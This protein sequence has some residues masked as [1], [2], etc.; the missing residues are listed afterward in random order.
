M[1]KGF[2]KLGVLVVAVLIGLGAFAFMNSTT[3]AQATNQERVCYGECPSVEFEASRVVEVDDTNNT[4][5]DGY[6]YIQEPHPTKNWGPDYCSKEETFSTTVQYGEKSQDPNHCHRPTAQSLNVPQ[7]AINDF[8]KLP[9]KKDKPVIQCEAPKPEKEV[10]VNV[11]ELSCGVQEVTLSGSF[12]YTVEVH[13]DYLAVYVDGVQVGSDILVD[14]NN[15]GWPNWSIAT[16]ELGVGTHTVKVELYDQAGHNGLITTH[17]TEFEIE[18][19]SE[20]PTPTPTP[21]D[22]PKE[23]TVSHAS[24][25]A[26]VCP[27]GVTINLPANPHVERNGSTAVVKW[28]QTEGDSANIYYKEVNSSNW[29][30]SVND[31]KVDN[32]DKFGQVTINDLD[33]NLGYTFGIQQK[34]GCGGGQTVTAIIIDGP[35][36]SLFYLSYWEWA[37]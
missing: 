1:N 28:F 33:P 20:E 4:C 22:Q 32:P 25:S 37:N 27:D 24:V 29:Q 7:W 35:A 16:D 36:P 23:Q 21:N 2:V 19:C 9:E 26:P 31:V 12:E 5:P 18:E 15:A 34:K 14:Q 3:P 11:S 8:N 6:D 10:T 17:E 30:H 13:S